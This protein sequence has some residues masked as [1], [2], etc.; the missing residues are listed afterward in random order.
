MRPPEDRRE[1]S[2]D[3]NGNDQ[4]RAMRRGSWILAGLLIPL[5]TILLWP[6]GNSAKAESQGTLLRIGVVATMFRDTPEPLLQVIMR[7][8]KSLLEAQAGITGQIVASGDADVLGQQ[9]TEN[10]VQLGV[11]HGVEFAWARRK[12][13]K[14]KPL[15]IA[16][17]QHPF[18]K[19][20][21]VVQRDSKVETVGDLLGQVVALPRMSR[22][23]CRLYLERRCVQPGFSPEKFYSKI[24]TLHDGEDALDAVC[25]GKVQAAVIDAVEF[26]QYH[27]DKPRQWAQLRSLQESE[28][29]PSAVIAFYPGSVDDGL[30][31]RVRDGMIAAKA[32]QRGQQLLSLCRI[33]SFEEIPADYEQML[34]N[35]VKA[36]PPAS[37]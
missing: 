35:I 3:P 2:K 18:L 9:L 15:M 37:R 14:L 33:T 31:L 6:V 17:N 23:H 7:P 5:L 32:T 1:A 10:H 36:Y 30:L 24:K 13:P 34:A 29:F 11:F 19:A 27:K 20:H 16:V 8:F 25:D 28:P 12:Y 21:L 22:E 26:D 4:E